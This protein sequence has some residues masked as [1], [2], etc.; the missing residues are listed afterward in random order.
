MSKVMERRNHCEQLSSCG[1]VISLGLIHNP[2]EKA[3]GGS[4]P[5][6]DCDMTAPNPMTEAYVSTIQDLS[7]YGKAN[8]VAFISSCF[9]LSKALCA[10]SVQ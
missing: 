4:I 6:T 5:S 1:T 3:I 9:N 10:P 7:R 8:D 2:R